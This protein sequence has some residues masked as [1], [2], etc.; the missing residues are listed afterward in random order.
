MQLQPDQ[1][2]FLLDIL[3]PQIAAEHKTTL[4]VLRAMPADHLDYRPDP[5]SMNALDLAWHIASADV[6]FLELAA[7]G[8]FSGSGTRPESL[9]T[10][11]DIAAWFEQAF[12]LSLEKARSLTGEQLVK[13]IQFHMFQETAL[14]Y[15]QIGLAHSIH[16]R[17]QLSTY[18]RP[19]GGKVPAIYGG[20][21]DE[22]MPDPTAQQASA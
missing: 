6:F 13:V 8:E 3:V 20:S 16:H 11:A 14:R 10:P 22:P 21:A 1:A 18:L 9:K 5:R 12:A 4:K 19:M 17:G 15:M 2:K 7:N